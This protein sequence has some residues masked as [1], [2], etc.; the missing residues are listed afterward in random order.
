M[1]ERGQRLVRKVVGRGRS[2]NLDYGW[3]VDLPLERIWLE[4]VQAVI[5][6]F[7]S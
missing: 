6:V 4:P 1:F 3:G 5:S 2:P 7:C